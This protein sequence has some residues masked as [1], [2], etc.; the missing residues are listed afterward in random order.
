MNK[1]FKVIWSKAKSC[2]V[3]ASELARAL[4]KSPGRGKIS[5]TLAAGI[6]TVVLSIYNHPVYADTYPPGSW[7]WYTADGYNHIYVKT[8]SDNNCI[9]MTA[10]FNH[11]DEGTSARTIYFSG[12]SAEEVIAE[13]TAGNGI[14]KSGNTLSAKAGTGITV[15]SSGISITAGTIASGNANAVTGGTLYSEL[16][17]FDNGNCVERPVV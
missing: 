9:S 16:R 13:I 1:V 14:S 5:K 10:Y 6:L 2:W 17:P 3:V 12:V 4:T 7:Q 8:D 11:P 15:N